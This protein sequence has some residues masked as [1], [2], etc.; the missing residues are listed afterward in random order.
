M[1]MYPSLRIVGACA[2]LLL[3]T[4][5]GYSAAVPTPD[6]LAS[7]FKSLPSTPEE[8]LP[9]LKNQ[10]DP[11]PGQIKHEGL[12]GHTWVK[13]PFIEN[14]ASFGFDRKGRLYVTEAHRFW[15]GVP[16][17]RGAS[18]L[19][20]G[21][22]QSVTV[23]DR[24]K[25]YD[26]NPNRFPEG[27]FTANA[28][29]IIR[30]ED[31][32]GNGAAD[33]R[34]VFSEH[35]N[36]ALDGVGF[37][38]LAEDDAVYFTCIPSLW[39]MT[40]S[41]DDGKADTHK[42]IVEG[43]GV[44]VSFIG[45]DL[46]GITRGPDGRLYFSIG[47][48][49]FHV[50]TPDGK[51]HNA[52][53]RG[54]IFRCESDGSGFEVFCHGLRNP[55][56]L[57]FDDYGNL[58]TFDNTGDIGDVAR[59][60]YAL[61]GSDSGWNMSHQSPHH[62]REILDWEAFHPEKSMW[63][64]E[65]MFE[66]FRPDQPQWVYPPASHVA[67]GPSGVTWMTGE[68]LPEN[69]RNKFLLANYRGPSVNCTILTIGVGP[70]GAGYTAT[71]EEVLVEGVGATD[72]ELGFDGNLYICDFGGGWSINQNGAIQVLSSKSGEQRKAGQR[73]QRA[74]NNGFA[75]SSIKQLV[76]HLHS[77]DR[78][79]R[80]AAQFELTKR[81]TKGRNAL[82]ATA[83]NST[84]KATTRLHAI[85]GLD[86]LG[87]T[88]IDVTKPLLALLSD[89]EPEI[90]ANAARALGSLKEASAA[91]PL[92]KL[93]KDESLRVRSLAAIALG[94]VVDPGN[95]KAIDALYD[96]A[97]ANGSGDIDPVIRH[98]VISGL[99]LIGTVDSAGFRVNSEEKEIRMTALLF[100]RRKQSPEAV[101][102]L[103]DDDAQIRHEAIRALYD[104]A[105]VDSTSG[106]R[107]AAIGT[108]ANE[109]P[110]TVQ[111]RVVAA[112]YR[113]GKATH[114]QT[115]I[116]MAAAGNLP[117][118]IRTA[119][120][121]ALR[122]WEK[123]IVTDPVLGHY[124]PLKNA[125]R[126]MK[127]L[128]PVIQKGL[129]KL[130]ASNPP[131]EI[132]ALA[133]KLADETGVALSEDAL[134]QQLANQELD[135]RLRSA[136]LDSLIMSSEKDRK[137]LIAKHLADSAGLVAATA[138]RHAFA[139]EYNGIAGIAKHA[140]TNGSINAAREAI[141][142]FTKATPTD[143]KNLWNR[144][145]TVRKELWLD[146]YLAINEIDSA[147]AAKLS[148]SNPFAV[149]HLS[150]TGGD[151]IRGES[152]FRNQGACL[153]CHKV[154]GEGGIQGPDLSSVAKRLPA[155]KLVESLVNPGAVIAEGFGTAMLTLKDDSLLMGRVAKEKESLLTIVTMDGKT[156]NV[157]R[158]DI[159]EMSPPNSAMPPLGAAL[160][161]Q[162][163]RD[164]VAYLKACT[165]EKKSDSASHGEK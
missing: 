90:R 27:W 118:S 84:A 143:I 102:F 132:A 91:E 96:M 75:D 56:E 97:S 141:K 22:F 16:D 59:M 20:R 9:Q 155:D 124:R 111:R 116:E 61:E 154:N 41:N 134:R 23:E 107:L 82:L 67:R 37:S 153:Q 152:V 145:V 57:A 53:G 121:H 95:E 156:E 55:Q 28:E 47:D 117:P 165:G 163:L 159:L 94:R 15:L 85:W 162:D 58:F 88:G 3:L 17:L 151:P 110:E 101:V 50:T 24:Q 106:D 78:R 7:R 31:R 158:D 86:Q 81:G 54:A 10:K 63:V 87:R 114:A 72:V 113:R 89:D 21:D 62:Y 148:E 115:L 120:L 69:L 73:V 11:F 142:G 92:I 68:S 6:E 36:S 40:D 126:S 108:A 83:K 129:R 1:N 8:D 161:P 33:H 32:D 150:E 4:A 164:L 135:P 123:A 104:T 133:L 64:A 70:K 98:S 34:S 103:N 136:A 138:I 74:F 131:S 109:L 46:H 119:S 76:V 160:P 44:H 157:K 60:V 13:F 30:L 99:D 29:R 149:F 140:I 52:V 51:V 105:A 122:L 65:N 128:G 14:P 77:S 39:K 127:A 43:F 48:R 93:T 147:A 26:D 5:S 137:T 35:F 79:L 19:V 38:V 144:R 12:E 71:S 146:L 45:H 25:L 139:H 49:G 80:Q 42:A 130:V 18:E 2:L 112:N 66:T 125:S 100:L